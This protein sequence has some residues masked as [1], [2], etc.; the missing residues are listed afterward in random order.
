MQTG[1]GVQNQLDEVCKLT[2]QQAGG[3]GATATQLYCPAP[4][5]RTALSWRFELR[6]VQPMLCCPL[7]SILHC[8]LLSDPAV[9]HLKELAL[10]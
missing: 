9:R 6:T 7:L 3:L 8:P 10:T 2:T 5:A 1:S 4:A